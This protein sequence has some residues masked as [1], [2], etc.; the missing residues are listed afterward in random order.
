MLSNN[1]H[2]EKRK[3]FGSKKHIRSVLR[4]QQQRLDVCRSL[5]WG[6]T[7]NMLF[8]ARRLASF[9]SLVMRLRASGVEFCDR[10]A[11]DPVAYSEEGTQTNHK[12]TQSQRT[13]TQ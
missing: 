4:A 12:I 3:T 10:I 7:T 2:Q 8:L 11:V 9:R 1:Q 6:C 13:I 5:R